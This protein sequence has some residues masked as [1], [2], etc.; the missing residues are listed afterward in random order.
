MGGRTVLS[1]EEQGVESSLETGRPCGAS[2][3]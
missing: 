2:R 3:G 1:Q